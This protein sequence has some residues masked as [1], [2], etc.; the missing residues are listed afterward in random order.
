MKYINYILTLGV[1]L[2]FTQSCTNLEEDLF[3]SFSEDNFFQTEDQIT[4]GFGAAYTNLYSLDNTPGYLAA[5]DLSTDN[6]CVPTRGSDWNDGGHWRRLHTQAWN[7]EDPV[8]NNTWDFVFKGIGDVNRLIFQFENLDFDGRDAVVAELRGLRAIF[9]MW[10]LDLFGNIPISDK[11][12]VPE[13]FLPSQASPSEVFAFVESELQAVLPLLSSDAGSTYGRVNKYVA[14]FAL[15]KLYLNAAIYTGS[16]RWG[17]AQAQFDAVIASGAY[18]FSSTYASMFA[19]DNTGNAE[20]IFAIPYDAVFAGGFVLVQQ[21]LHYGNQQ[22]YN[23]TSQPWNGWSALEDFYNSYEDGD[24]RQTANFVVGPQFTAGGARVIDSGAEA[25]DPDGPPLTLTPEINELGLNTLRQAGARIGKYAFEQGSTPNMN[26]DFPLFRYTD[27]LLSKAECHMRMGQNM[28][29]ALDLVNQV[30]ARAGVAPFTEL[31]EE[32]LLAERGRELFFEA[33]RRT[34]MIRFGR[35]NDAW[36][37]KT[38]TDPHVNIYP[39]PRNQLDANS[40]LNQNPG[41]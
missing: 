12:E 36:W 19:P 25:N 6:S 30:R 1:I 32:N 41:Y 40:N 38:A 7:A 4:A 3:D 15:G 34:D 33:I 21:T 29:Q 14:Q 31:T 22:T 9:H 24:V 10:G 27:A 5:Q 20:L 35:F 16:P 37:E 28:S 13:G 17:D 2:L 18:S 26:N 39:I 23:L 8:V 11:F